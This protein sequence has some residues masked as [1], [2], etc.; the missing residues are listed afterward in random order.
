MKKLSV[1]IGMLLFFCIINIL[2]P[3][4]GATEYPTK[5]IILVVPYGAGGATDLA[6]RAVAA[7]IPKYLRQGVI[8]D[9]RPGAVGQIARR[10]TLNAKPD[11]YSMHMMAVGAGCLQP[12]I[13]PKQ[14]IPWDAL[15]Y[16]AITQINPVLLVV[17][18][19]S[20]FKSFQ[21]IVKA[22]KERPKKL[23]FSSSGAGSITN[24][25]VQILL[26]TLGLKPDGVIHIPF[27][28]GGAA[29]A[30]VLGGHV[31]FDFEVS[32]QVMPHV[33]AGRLRALAVTTPQRLKEIPDVPTTGELGFPQIDNLGWRGVIGPPKLPDYVVATWSSALEKLSKDKAW[34]TMLKKFGD[35]PNYMPPQEARTFVEK[36]NK[37]YHTLFEKLGIVVK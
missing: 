2:A 21:D 7:T 32:P 22:I 10:H 34:L 27:D 29:V 16:V 4:K 13:A 33:R 12:S 6:A 25:C 14:S 37:R 20:P 35:E 8:V 23:S 30:A 1:I 15:T 5:P 31:D 36:E 28:S 19:D 3:A 18:S 9:N 24:A 11:G 26:N 17:K